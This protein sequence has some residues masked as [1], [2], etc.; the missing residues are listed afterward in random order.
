MNTGPSMVRVLFLNEL[1]MMIRDKRSVTASI[2]LPLLL[3]PLMLFGST[4]MNKKREEKL[5]TTIYQYAVTGSEAASVRAWLE[6]AKECVAQAQKTN[7]SAAFS[8]QELQVQEPWGAL[9]NDRIHLVIE[10]L[11]SKEAAAQFGKEADIELRK[12]LATGAPLVRISGRGDRDE[13]GA[14]LQRME[15][16]LARARDSERGHLLVERGFSLPLQKIAAVSATDLAFKGHV[17]GLT[18]GRTLTLF[19]LFFMMMAGAVVASDLIAGEKERGTL[20]TL[21]TS[22]AS[23]VEIVTAKHLVILTVA[24]IITVIQAA[25]LLVYVGFKVIPVPADFAAAVPPLVAVLLLLLFLPIAGVVASVLLFTSGYARSYKEAQLYFTPVFLLA[26]LPALVPLLPGLSL[27]SAI[28]LVPVA[29]LAMATKEIL[30]GVFDWPMIAMA[31]LVTAVAA[32]WGMRLTVRLLSAE[33]LVGGAELDVVDFAGGP[34]LFPRRV[35]RWFAMLWALLLILGNYTS[36]SDLR[37]QLLLNVVVLFFGASMLMVWRYR[38]DPIAAFAL[39]RPKPIVWFAVL[40]AAPSGI[41]AGTGLFRLANLVF[42]VP[43]EI[44]QGFAQTLVPQ[45]TPV[46]QLF[47]FLAVLPGVFEELTFRGVLL[48]GLHTRLRPGTLALVVGLIFGLFHAALF[49]LA[50]TAFLGVLLTAVTLLT[51][52]IFPA[53]LWHALNNAL[54]L[55]VGYYDIAASDLE[56]PLYLLGA[57]GLAAAFWIIWRNRTPYPGL[58]SWRALKRQG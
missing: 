54:G 32:I 1:R 57:A 51:G 56:P 35:L 50:P 52:S 24:A 7:R 18:L 14:A 26:L 48:H 28:V 29:N 3:M 42:P 45:G 58:R 13:S 4:W 2:V 15:N 30:V 43:P 16:A 17:A 23:R 10:G 39:R 37:L 6:R 41:L 33:R 55:L 9:T 27:R 8:F 25:N 19:I 46:W 40:A 36:H 44:L 53:M 49:R 47:L 11:S 34:K 22:G 5:R 21:L 38:L 20:E 31:W 12:S